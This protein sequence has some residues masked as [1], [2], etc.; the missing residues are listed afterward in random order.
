MGVNPEDVNK[1]LTEQG[2]VLGK[3]ECDNYKRGSEILKHY[4]LSHF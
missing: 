1:V 2:Y 4:R 3:K